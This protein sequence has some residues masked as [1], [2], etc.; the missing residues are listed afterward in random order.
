M[1]TF[2]E[3]RKTLKRAIDCYLDQTGVKV[4]LIISL[5][6]DNPNLLWLRE[7][8]LE[9]CIIPASEH[10]GKCPNG[11]FMQLNKALPL[12]RSEWFAFT[13]AD[14]VFKKNKLHTEVSKC[15]EENKEVCYSAYWMATENA[16]SDKP[17]PFQLI[18][19]HDYNYKIHLTN[20]FVA[21]LSVISKRLVDKYLPFNLKYNNYAYWDLWLRIYEGEGNVF[22]YNPKPTWYYIQHNTDMHNQRKKSSQLQ[23]EANRDRQIMLNH[24]V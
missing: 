18:E 24:H 9:L 13:S 2:N 8:A 12:M 20:N 23:Q 3:D 1:N 11:S 15:I 17:N 7:E 14:D 10:P 22:V 21:D 4:Q 6:D 19:F 5:L 16:L